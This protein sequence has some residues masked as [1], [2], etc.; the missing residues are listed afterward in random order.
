MDSDLVARSAVLAMLL[1]VSAT[2]KSG[3][4][5]RDHSFPDIS[6]EH[7]LASSVSVYSVYKKLQKKMVRLEN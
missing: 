2:P 3:N 6:Y 7:F 1:E 5:D 4:V